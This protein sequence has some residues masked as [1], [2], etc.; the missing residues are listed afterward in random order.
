MVATKTTLGR[1]PSFLL[2]I[3]CPLFGGTHCQGLRKVVTS[4]SWFARDF[5]ILAWKPL[6]LENT[7]VLGELGWQ[8]YLY[9]FLPTHQQ[10]ARLIR[11]W[12]AGGRLV[13]GGHVALLSKVNV[14]RSL[15]IHLRALA[16]CWIC[17][18]AQWASW[19]HDSLS[20][21]AAPK[22][23]RQ[24]SGLA[25]KLVLLCLSIY[26]PFRAGE[27]D[28]LLENH[29]LESGRILADIETINSLVP[30]WLIVPVAN[31]LQPGG[32]GNGYL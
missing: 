23:K 32:K 1:S 30:I 24:S 20:A 21:L 31:W 6:H 25:N 27:G 12:R 5:L 9:L 28:S 18:Q 15:L 17:A 10:K 22:A 26:L 3:L 4:A 14:L 2:F 19:A 13:L 29:D 8:V 7:S 16:S 11:S